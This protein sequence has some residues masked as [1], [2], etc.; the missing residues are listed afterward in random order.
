MVVVGAVVAD[1][2]EKRG[3][4]GNVM[5][6]CVHETVSSHLFLVVDDESAIHENIVV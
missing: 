4:N 3:T 1:L 2:E 6:E 5:A